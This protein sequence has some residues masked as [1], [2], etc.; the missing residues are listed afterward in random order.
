VRLR[1]SILILG[2][3]L[4][5]TAAARNVDDIELT[6]EVVAEQLSE[7][8]VLRGI[9]T[10]TRQIAVLSRP[11]ESTGRFLLSE[12]GLQWQQEKPFENVIVADGKRVAERMADGPVRSID[13]AE[14]P[15]V[16]EISK[17]FLDMFRG[18]HA[19]LEDNFTVRFEQEGDAWE[20]G[21]TPRSS[22]MSAA[23]R[24]I[25]LQGRKHIEQI[26]VSSGAADEMTIRFFDLQTSPE[27][28]TE[29]EIELYAW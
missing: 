2:L 3:F 5:G 6:L 19:N 4:A 28:L 29:H 23:I 15:I 27:Q 13:G 21:L 11:L 16:V 9:Y 8:G 7:P 18:Q 14:Q 26:S 17:I 20:I 1:L 10:Q 12:K 22:P 24:Q 25:K